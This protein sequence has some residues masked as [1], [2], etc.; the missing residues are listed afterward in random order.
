[1]N[2]RFIFTT[3][4]CPSIYPQ[5]YENPFIFNCVYLS[6]PF[7]HEIASR[8]KLDKIQKWGLKCL[9][10]VALLNVIYVQFLIVIVS[11]IVARQNELKF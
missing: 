7:L 1:M 6:S 2:F 4:T 3:Y 8:N 9:L 10:S 5:F 11:V